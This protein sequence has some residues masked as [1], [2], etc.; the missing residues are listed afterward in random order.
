M[1][2]IFDIGKGFNLGNIAVG[3]AV[4]LLAP[5]VLP[6]LGSALRPMAKALIKGGITVYEMGREVAAEARETVEDLNAEV[7]SERKQE[8]V[9][10]GLEKKALGKSKTS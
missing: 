4:V 8:Q 7:Q 6:V 10:E 3:A 5:A 1:G 9:V 2:G